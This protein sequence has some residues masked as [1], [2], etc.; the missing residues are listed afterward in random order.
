MKSI[1]FKRTGWIY[2]PVS[3]YGTIRDA[4]GNNLSD[5]GVYGYYPEGTFRF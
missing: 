1:W 3:R 2:L 5:S 4:P